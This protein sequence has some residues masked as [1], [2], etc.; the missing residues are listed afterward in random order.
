MPELAIFLIVVLA[1]VA[2]TFTTGCS[3]FVAEVIWDVTFGLL[4]LFLDL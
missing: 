2:F 3:W 4:E 1:L